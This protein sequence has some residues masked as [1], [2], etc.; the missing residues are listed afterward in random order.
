MGKDCQLLGAE[1]IERAVVEAFLQVCER[2]GQEAVLLVQE[3][4]QQQGED[5]ERAWRLQIEKAEYEA[6]RAERQYDAV[7]PENRIVARELE[8]RWNA[9][10]EELDVVR[11]KARAAR[12]QH[13]ALTNQEL[14][15]ARTLGGDLQAVWSAS[16]TADRDRKRLLRTLI[17]EGK[18]EPS[19]IEKIKE[20]YGIIRQPF[21]EENSKTPLQV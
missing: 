4:S 1:R 15:M 13:P 12:A 17:E 2:A 7:E 3:Q 10:M 14:A 5:V 18:L 16:T 9:R 11:A 19:T 8:R 20:I 21:I 6:Q